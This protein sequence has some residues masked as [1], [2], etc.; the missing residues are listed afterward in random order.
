[1]PCP[2][3][4]AGGLCAS[5]QEPFC[6]KS[7]VIALLRLRCL[8]SDPV[9]DVGA[10]KPPS[11]SYFECG[12]LSRGGKPVDSPLRDL[13]EVGDLLDGEDLAPTGIDGHSSGQFLSNCDRIVQNFQGNNDGARPGRL[14]CN[15]GQRSAPYD[16]MRSDFEA[17]TMESDWISDQTS[18]ASSAHIIDS[19]SRRGDISDAH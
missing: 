16:V 13:Q 15:A 10:R 12:N 3:A 4:N 1:M 18:L 5:C 11:P 2:I 14:D 7:F 19:V 6:A 9:V 17:T 8:L